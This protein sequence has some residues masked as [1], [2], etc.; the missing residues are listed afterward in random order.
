MGP[1]E[2]IFFVA[3]FT[4]DEKYQILPCCPDCQHY[5]G[6]FQFCSE[7]AGSLAIP[8][9]P[10][11]PGFHERGPA[12]GGQHGIQAEIMEDG[13][14]PVRGFAAGREKGVD[15]TGAGRRC[16]P[17]CQLVLLYICHESYQHSCGLAGLSCLPRTDDTTGLAV[18]ERVA[19]PWAMGGYRP[20]CGRLCAAGFP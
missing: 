6:V 15:L 12:D 7:A 4:P 19:E 9:H 11:L 13:P 2:G 14:T 16:V 8:G 10:V 18:P 3:I 5:M 17:D 20:Q 1:V